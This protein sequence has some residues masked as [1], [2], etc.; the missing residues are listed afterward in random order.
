MIAMH[1]QRGRLLKLIKIKFTSWR[2][3]SV[4]PR[5]REIQER[6]DEFSKRMNLLAANAARIRYKRD[7]NAE[8]DHK[9]L[10][11]IAADRGS[12]DAGR[13]AL[14][15]A[16]KAAADAEV[17]AAR[18]HRQVGTFG[19]QV[20]DETGSRVAVVVNEAGDYLPAQALYT[21]EVVDEN[22]PLPLWASEDR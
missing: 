14:L 8:E 9:A 3:H 15:S 13:M 11:A 2:D 5:A 4:A 19:Y 17:G 12:L 20:L 1:V 7:G 16:E 18:A 6:H 21:F 22:P 10:A